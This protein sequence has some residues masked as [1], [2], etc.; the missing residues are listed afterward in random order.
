MAVDQRVERLEQHLAVARSAE[1][2]AG[3]AEGDVLAPAGLDAELVAGQ[4]YGRAQAL[5]ALARLVHRRAEVLVGIALEPLDRHV[6]LAAGDTADSL[7]YPLAIT[8]PKPALVLL[9]NCLHSRCMYFRSEP[10]A[11]AEFVVGAQ[12]TDVP[13]TG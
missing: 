3:V 7:R 9:G 1:P 5:E 13:R 11:N 4:P 2:P 6:E 12:R 10:P 8:Q